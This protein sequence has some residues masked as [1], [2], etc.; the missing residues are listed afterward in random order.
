[1]PLAR[2][3]NRSDVSS[4]RPLSRFATTVLALV[5]ATLLGCSE[6]KPPAANWQEF[7]SKAGRY[8]ATMPPNVQ[9][10]E[11]KDP[12]GM[13]DAALMMDYVQ[14]ANTGKTFAV[15]Y[16]DYQLG[17]NYADE[18]LAHRVLDGVVSGVHE[19]NKGTIER[20]SR[21][22][23]GEHHGQECLFL[24][25]D[26]GRMR[27]LRAYLV[28]NRLYQLMA[29]WSPARGETSAEAEKFMNSFQVTK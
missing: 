29:D 16:A 12:E 17:P 6:K 28:D 20:Q 10:L 1:M 15:T 2:L 21:I 19:S 27:L 9:H 25:G 24:L 26:K 11:Q 8:R 22:K 5:V 7:V 4:A 18:T 13:L 23:L 14:P 3:K